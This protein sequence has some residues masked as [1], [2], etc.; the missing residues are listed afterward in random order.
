MV[1]TSPRGLRTHISYF[2]DFRH[3]L[4]LQAETVFLP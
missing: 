1:L 4:K 2:P 3:A